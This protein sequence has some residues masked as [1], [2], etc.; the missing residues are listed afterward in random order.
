[1]LSLDNAYNEEEL[2]AFDER[3]RRGLGT[4]D[5]VTYVAELKID[6]LSIALTYEDGAL[7]RGATR[8]DGVRGE[9]VTHNVRTVRA[10]PLRLQGGP[11]GRIEIRGEVY[12]SKTAF[13][14]INKEQEDAGEPLYANARN[15]AAGT[16]RNLDPALVAKRGLLAWTYQVVWPAGAADEPTH[17]E[18]LTELKQ[19][20]APV[21]PHWRALRRH[22]RGRRVLRRPGATSASTLTFETD[23]VVIKV[24][25]LGSARAA[26]LHVEVPAL[27]DRVQVPGGAAR[28]RCCTGSRST[29]AA[30]ARRRRLRCSSPPWWRARRSRWPRCTTRTTS[31]ARTFARASW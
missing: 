1:M 9:D 12:L 27:G 6:G 29:S 25:D 8:G 17:A 4:S 21:E 14:R 24:N 2:R 5:P 13:E 28:S 30:P 7:V 3:V 31:S 22:R 18:M 26:W 23:G 19:W 20:G 15:T 16:M 11:P 10:I